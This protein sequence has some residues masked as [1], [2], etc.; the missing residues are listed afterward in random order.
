MLDAMDA[1]TR[2]IMS[3]EDPVEYLLPGVAQ[4]ELAPRRGITYPRAIRALLH[5]DPDVILVGEMRDLET[6]QMCT[7]SAITGH[8]LL[9]TMHVNTAPGTVKR[10][11]D[12]GM[13]PFHVNATVRGIIAQRLV[14]RLC[15]ECRQN[16][17]LSPHSIPPEVTAFAEA[18]PDAT[19]YS[20]GKCDACKGM[21]YR[22]RIGIHEILIPDEGFRNTVI[23]GA[24]EHALR[25]AA[26]SS[27]MRGML[28]C[29]L[30]KA[31]Q[32]I[33]SIEEV[34]RVVPRT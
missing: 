23:A 10:L 24:E 1:D 20:P 34:C 25:Q 16:T 13:E 32:G 18:H 28:E 22:G 8:L 30:E 11:L 17:E 33:T 21:G 31:A 19:F 2:C 3:V 26:L 9:S 15:P 6:I 4:T 12:M 5:H 7:E 14:R 29:G 27:G